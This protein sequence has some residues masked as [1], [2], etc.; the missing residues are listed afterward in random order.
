MGKKKDYKSTFL[1]CKPSVKYA[2]PL[3]PWLTLDILVLSWSI[4]FKVCP[5]CYEFELFFQFIGSSSHKS[6]E[7]SLQSGSFVSTS[8]IHSLRLTPRAL[9]LAMSEYIIAARTAASSFPQNRQFFRPIAK[10][11]MAFPIRLSKLLDNLAENSI[12]PQAL[13]RKN[14]LFCGNDDAAENAAVIYSL[15][16]LQ[17]RRG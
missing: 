5:S 1:K 8:V 9:Q 7:V 14:Y 2:L 11:R 12:R 3:Q 4:L 17:S 13:G 6:F 15:M 16:V 10:G